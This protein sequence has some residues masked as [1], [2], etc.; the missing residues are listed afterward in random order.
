[1]L[2]TYNGKLLTIP[3]GGLAGDEACCC[4]GVVGC[5]TN[6]DDYPAYEITISGIASGCNSCDNELNGTH[7][8]IR[9]GCIW[10]IDDSGI[11]AE[12]ELVLY[13]EANEWYLEIY[14]N[15]ALDCYY[16]G[17]FTGDPIASTSSS[18]EGTWNLSGSFEGNFTGGG[19]ETKTLTCTCVVSEK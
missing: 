12:V 17:T 7:D 16:L 13:C 6:C 11:P 2:W 3:G 15:C 9:G 10:G 4:G 14:Y 1:M 18:P 8:L 5:P 19:V